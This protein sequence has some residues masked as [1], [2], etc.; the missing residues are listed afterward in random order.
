MTNEEFKK[1]RDRIGWT[2]KEAAEALG[3]TI[4]QISAIENNRSRITRTV[5]N[6][7]TLYRF[8]DRPGTP[9]ANWPRNTR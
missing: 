2:Q 3:L 5:E 9:T 1:H 6:L 4:A 8:G 7:F